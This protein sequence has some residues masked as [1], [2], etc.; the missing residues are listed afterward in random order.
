MPAIEYA[1]LFRMYL[2]D[3]NGTVFS[4]AEVDLIFDTAEAFY[5]GKSARVHLA[6]AV[7]SG[8][9]MLKTDAAKRASYEQN[10]S[11]E[12][13]SDISKALDKSIDDWKKELDAALSSDVQTVR[14]GNLRP[15]PTR[16][17]E[18]PDA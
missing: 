11:S 3:P 1:T 17:K 16:L 13:L 7:L 12:D 15:Y 10:N 8:L 6:A 18:Y 2:S 14:I 4:D 5:P 9:R